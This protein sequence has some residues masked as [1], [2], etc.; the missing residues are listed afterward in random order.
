MHLSIRTRAK[1]DKVR[2][3]HGCLFK[4]KETSL[5]ENERLLLNLKFLSIRDLEV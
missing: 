1:H 4:E 3:E 5:G 2:L